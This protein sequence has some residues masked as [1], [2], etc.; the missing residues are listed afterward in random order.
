MAVAA[1]LIEKTDEQQ[2][3]TEMVR[4]FADEQILPQAEHFDAA[5]EF[6]AGI[7]DQMKDLGLFGVT[8]PE[9]YGGMG[10]D[11]T[12]YA[13]IVEEL[14]RG[15]ISIS[16]VI[17]T[18]FIGSYLLMKFGTEDQRRAFLPRM[19]TG[20]IRAAF[21]LS[22]PEMGSDV[23]AIKSHARK[24]DD[25][26]YEINGQKMWVT[27]GLM[28]GLVFVLV[29]TDPEADP[30]HRGF[31]CFI[32]EKEP[33]VSENTGAHAGLN[34]PPKIR[35]LGY[36]GVES[37]E[38]VFDGYRCPAANILGGE[39]DGLNRGFGQMMDA[40]EVGRVNVAA[41]GV[42]IA[43]RAL[44]LALRYSQERRTFGRPIAQHQAIQFKLADMATQVEAARL[45]TMRAARLKDAGERSD[46]EAGMAKLFAS[47]AG[48]FCVEQSFRIHGGYGYSK[49]YEIERLYRD[50]P[51][52]LIGEGTSEIQRMVI[53]KKLLERHKI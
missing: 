22:E 3:I 35:K 42:G 44:E 47:E 5:D 46:L 12:T 29:K 32:A 16:G 39:Q 4:Q 26:T 27:N 36:K 50:A 7:V 19:A 45:L 48:L 53:G 33:G 11:L 40:L 8:I 24:V 2:A 28:S 51:L 1:N 17:N 14:S 15:W 52:L 20:E 49:E 21:S 18:H 41:R 6:P 10:L 38:L 23:Q 31:T 9:E 37:T 13:M 34:V 30:R 43:Q 25:A